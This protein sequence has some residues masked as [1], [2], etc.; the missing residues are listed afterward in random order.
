MLALSQA[1][2]DGLVLSCHDLSEGGLAVAAAEMSLAGGV[3]VEIDLDAVPAERDAL[4]A[5]LFAESTGRFLVEVA[6]TDAPRFEEMIASTRAASMAMVGRTTREERF[7]AR[8]HGSTVIDLPVTQIERA[9]K[10]IPSAT[11]TGDNTPI[12]APVPA[13]STPH[14]GLR[15]AQPRALVLTAAGVNCD[16]ETMEACR[17]AGAD[18]EAV[19]VN[20]LL[21]GSAGHLLDYGMLVLAGGFSYGDHL[22]AG[23]M[24]A[25]VL[26]HG[27]LD[28]LETFIAAGR[29]VLGICNGFQ[30]LA[31]L[32]LLGP[33][34]LVPNSDGRFH[35]EWTELHV[36]P[37]PCIFLR[38]F[39]RM[40]LPIAHGEGRVVMPPE[41][42]DLVLPF[43][44]LRYR[45]NPNGSMA[46]IAG[47]CNA[48]G[49]VFGLMPHPERYLTP[50]HHPLRS[51]APPA[52]VPFFGNAIRYIQEEL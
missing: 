47:V 40:E 2:R 17:L 45:R 31:R 46:G 14:I 32:G 29:P 10:G 49:N 28:T 50:L 9:W 22:G 18:V 52:G 48:G 3:G 16:R 33:I 42:V 12:E 24:L 43:A 7:A 11:P 15:R 20:R 39:E 27:L 5:L 13:C 38:G 4:E 6:E 44:P 34:S 23:T 36:Q 30:V 1:I 8:H 19:H 35:C 51:G 37:S 26:R 25:A 41:C 21:H